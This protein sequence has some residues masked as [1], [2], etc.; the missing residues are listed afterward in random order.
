MSD[1]VKVERIVIKIG[2]KKHEFSMEEAKEL[3]KLLNDLLGEKEVIYIPYSQPVYVEPHRYIPYPYITPTVPNPYSPWIITRGT[4][5]D[6]TRY[7]FPT[8]ICT[9]NDT[10]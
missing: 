2:D 5:D 8:V 4:S 6:P 7:A 1:E 3:Q 9:Y 10:N